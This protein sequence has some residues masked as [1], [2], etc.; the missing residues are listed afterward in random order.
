MS[1][2][3]ITENIVKF[4]KDKMYGEGSGHDWFHD[5]LRGD[6]LIRVKTL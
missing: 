6:W 4:V 2:R 3:R 1:K 5:L